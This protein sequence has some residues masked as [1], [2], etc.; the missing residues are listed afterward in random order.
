MEIIDA[1]FQKCEL[2]NYTVTFPNVFEDLYSAD[3]NFE[4]VASNTIIPC[5]IFQIHNIVTNKIAVIFV[6]GCNVKTFDFKKKFLRWSKAAEHL[7]RVNLKFPD[8]VVYK[9]L[10]KS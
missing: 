4:M 8:V 10:S 1:M 9:D 3:A 5:K 6:N 2:V 7:L